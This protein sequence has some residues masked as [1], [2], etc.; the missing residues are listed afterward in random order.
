M[1][2]TPGLCGLY[3]LVNCSTGWDLYRKY[4]YLLPKNLAL[5]A[6]IT[7]I[8]RIFHHIYSKREMK[9]LQRCQQFVHEHETWE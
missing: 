7:T 3:I 2:I 1:V 8:V 6:M 9:G 5:Y 4:F